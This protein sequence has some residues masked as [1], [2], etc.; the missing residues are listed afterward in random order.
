M[1]T[2]IKEQELVKLGRKYTQIEIDEESRRE[3]IKSA[4]WRTYSPH[5]WAWTIQEQANMALYVLWAAQ[6]L[7][8]IAN[9]STGRNI[10]H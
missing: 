8:M 3:A 9:I 1:D 5:E 10:T 2:G 6:R 4:I 7:E